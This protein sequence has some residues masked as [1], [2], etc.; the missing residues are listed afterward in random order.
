MGIAVKVIGCQQI[1]STSAPTAEDLAC[2]RNN[3]SFNLNMELSIFQ[4]DT[5]EITQ[6]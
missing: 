1:E 6:Y 4:R 2:L 3:I 5:T